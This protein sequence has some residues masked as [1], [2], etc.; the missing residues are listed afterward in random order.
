APR[1]AEATLRRHLNPV[2]LDRKKLLQ[3]LADLDAD[4]F[5]TRQAAERHL[6]TLGPDVEGDLLRLQKSKPSLGGG[7]R[8]ERLLQGGVLGGGRGGWQ[9][10]GALEV[11]EQLRTPGAVA[12]LRKLAAEA[13][14][15]ILRDGA[16]EALGRLRERQKEKS[17]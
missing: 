12:L 6:A 16:K 1:E 9:R 3:A 8:A 7:R 2:V 10:W 13:H 15:A 5:D 17:R 11:L 14:D 4:E